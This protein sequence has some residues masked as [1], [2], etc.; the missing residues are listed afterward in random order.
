M[1]TFTKINDFVLNLAEVIDIDGDALKLA[2]TNTAP[3]S[4]SSNPTADTNGVLA[5]ITEIAYTN[6]SDDL[7]ADR[8]LTSG[9]TTHTQTSGTFTLDYGADIVITATGGALPTFQYIYLWDDTPTSPAD[10]L[11]N[12]WDQG[13]GV[14]LAE[15]DTATIQFNASGILTLA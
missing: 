12:I 5:N 6:Y 13:A 1:A 8:V 15:N 7:T 2:F 9:T 10:P 14:T 3:A 11:I 4:E